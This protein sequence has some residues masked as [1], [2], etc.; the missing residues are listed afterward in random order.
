MAT[1]VAMATM[2]EGLVP[3]LL[4]ALVEGSAEEAMLVVVVEVLRR[5]KS[6]D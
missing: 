1:L 5:T 2:T 6:G 4:R 3:V